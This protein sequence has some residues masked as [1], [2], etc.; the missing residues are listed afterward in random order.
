MVRD[1]LAELDQQ[2]AFHNPRDRDIYAAGGIYG[3][4]Q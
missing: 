4:H 2:Q 3:L 1:G